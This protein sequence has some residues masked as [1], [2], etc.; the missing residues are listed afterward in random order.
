MSRVS[1]KSTVSNQYKHSVTP[2]TLLSLDFGEYGVTRCIEGQLGENYES[3]ASNGILRLQP[4]V[5]PPYG[6]LYLNQA[7][8][9]VPAH[10]L[11][12]HYDAMREGMTSERGSKVLNPCFS[13]SNINLF[14]INP[15]FSYSSYLLST[16]LGSVTDPT[17][18][19]SIALADKSDF[20][21]I[22]FENNQVTYQ[23]YKLTPIGRRYYK[24]LKSLGFDFVQFGYDPNAVSS[25][26]RDVLIAASTFY[27]NIYPLL[28]FCKIYVD[29]FQNGHFYNSSVLTS[30]LDHI[31]RG[32][33]FTLS[34]VNL[35]VVSSTFAELTREGLGFILDSIMVPHKSNMYT[36]AF[37]SMVSPSGSP[38]SADENT[39]INNYMNP[40]SGNGVS[41][42]VTS[43][44][45]NLPVFGSDNVRTDVSSGFLTDFG[46]RTLN[47]FANFVYKRNLVGS[48]A[49]DRLFANF[50]VEPDERKFN[51]VKKLSEVSQRIN[52]H[53]V[54][55][56]ADTYDS[57]TQEGKVVGAYSGFAAEGMQLNYNYKLNEYGYII[58]VAYL[59]IDPII[60][61]GFNPQVLRINSLDFWTPGFDAETVRA[62]P[63]CEISHDK[64][65]V[66]STSN[67]HPKDIYGFVDSYDD[68]RQMRDIVAGDFVHEAKAFI[69]ARD[70]SR[71]GPAFK[72]QT[73][74]VHY[75]GKVSNPD[76]TN[77]FYTDSSLGDRFYLGL[78]FSID[79]IS[80]IKNK[81]NSLKVLAG[82]TT[83]AVGGNLMD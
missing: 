32:Q 37:N 72:P 19:S 59:T 53:P 21:F 76:L 49:V 18:A 52:F 29:M 47:W 73:D 4:Q 77:P 40:S 70:Y 44:S 56:N 39:N 31:R 46:L 12:E 14:F 74:E 80:G 63:S 33:S 75:Y 50:G 36:E 68:Y 28:A 45:D 20:T 78:D 15:S 11:Y 57:N 60:L 79:Y 43:N 16:S 65:F 5:F 10:Q 62:I 27:P 64:N 24:L 17:L 8:F 66:V 34:G 3:I 23:Y 67:H 7:A 42:L 6:K 55:S 38:Y 25:A 82:D 35:F 69:F 13:S 9:F 83:V 71:L 41:P 26:D 1:I 81:D 48:K 58:Q 30:L 2:S 54:V 51:F 22:V 61:H